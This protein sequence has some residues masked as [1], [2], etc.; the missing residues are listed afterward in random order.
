M[1]QVNMVA[2]T[3]LT[4]ALFLPGMIKQKRGA[5][6]NVSSTAGFLPIADFAVYAATKAYV[7][8]FTEAMRA[9]LH[10]TGVTV[11][12]LCPDRSTQNSPRSQRA[13]APNAIGLRNSST[14]PP[15]KSR[16]LVSPRWSRTSHSSF[17]ASL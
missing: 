5:I 9:E 11:T 14:S 4:R 7:T 8:S 13:P 16:A 1:M 2:L 17:P 3:R 15:K 12:S 10:G 6:L